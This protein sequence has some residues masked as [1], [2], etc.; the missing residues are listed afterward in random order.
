MDNPDRTRTVKILIWYLNYIKIRRCGM[1]ANKK[2]IHQSSF[3]MDVS[4]YMQLSDEVLDSQDNVSCKFMI[5]DSRSDSK[6]H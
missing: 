6:G 4:N 1:L 2:N 3:E 5:K